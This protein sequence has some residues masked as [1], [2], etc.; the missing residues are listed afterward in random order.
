MSEGEL[1]VDLH[2]DQNK[3]FKTPLGQH[4]SRDLARSHGIS[5]GIG[6]VTDPP[7]KRDLD[8]DLAEDIDSGERVRRRERRLGRKGGSGER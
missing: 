3:L 5:P 7:A 1:S 8:R 6:H 4:I 2:Q